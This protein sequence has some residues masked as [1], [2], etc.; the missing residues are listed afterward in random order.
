M[1]EGELHRDLGHGKQALATLERAR[2]LASNDAE[3][4]TAWIATAS[5]HRVM[6]MIEPGLAALDRAEELASRSDLTRE[7]ARIGYLR[8]NLNFAR[9]DVEACRVSHERALAFAQQASDAECEAQAL[10]GLA[11]A[12]YAQGRLRS[13]Y[14]A[15]QRC[16]AICDR[17]GLTR[18]ALANRCMMAIVDTYLE[19]L[20]ES[21]AAIG[22]ARRLAHEIQHRYAEAMALETTGLLL[23]TYG[24]FA[25]AKE[26]VLEALSFAREIGARRWEALAAYCLARILWHEGAHDEARG[27]AELAWRIANEVGP[28][29]AGPVALGALAYTAASDDERARFLAEGERLL[30]QGCVS[31]CYFGFLRDAMETSLE[32]GRWADAERYA[33]ELEDYVRAEPLPVIDFQVARTSAMRRP[34]P[35]STR[36]CRL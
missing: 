33:D 20:D 6:S 22:R 27:Y 14:A 31:H 5:A 21:L 25:E 26:V 19:R 32:H 9:G 23:V 30:R 1:L 28:R 29:F 24:R 17:E 2:E 12:L 4:C 7:L 3:Q 34:S 35:R 11:D 18:F 36:R 16:V 10:S 8:G 13:A 15:F